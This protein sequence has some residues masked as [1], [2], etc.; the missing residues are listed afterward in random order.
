MTQDEQVEPVGDGDV[1]LAPGVRVPASAVGFTFSRSGGP[2]GQNVNKLSTRAQ[3]RIPMTALRLAIGPDAAERLALALGPS[4]L[5]D[6]GDV[7]IACDESRSQHTNRRGC[8][9]RLRMMLIEAT[10]PV[11]KRRKT[12]PTKASKRRRLDGKSHRGD[13]KRG[14]SRPDDAS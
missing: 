8:M 5:T 12:R 6:S 1:E 9:E 4:R 2:G 10:R 14:R 11:R 3:M 7:L 13:I